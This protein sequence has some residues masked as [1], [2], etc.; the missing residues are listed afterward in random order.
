MVYKNNLNETVPLLQVERS[1]RKL[2]LLQ[3]EGPQHLSRDWGRKTD[4]EV[5]WVHTTRKG[6]LV[7]FKLFLL[8][9][10]PVPGSS[11]I[12]SFTTYES[13]Q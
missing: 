10:T 1:L 5:P 11:S 6:F 12:L 3:W 2:G 4:Q 8:S 9:K 7:V 13:L